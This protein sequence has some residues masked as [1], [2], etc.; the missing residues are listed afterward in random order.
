MKLKLKGA[1]LISL[2]FTFFNGQSQTIEITPSYGYQFGTKL[3]YGGSYIK[4]ESSDQYG[5]S[6]AVEMD[7]DLMVGVAYTRMSTELNIRDG[8]VND[9]I[10]ATL[11]DLN[12]DWIL[13]EGTRYFQTGKVR[14]FAGGGLGMVIV[15]PQNVDFDLRPNGLESQTRFAFSFKGGVNIMFSDR[16]GLNLQ[17]NLYVPVVWGGLYIGTGGSGVGAGSTTIMGGFSGGLVF[18][19]GD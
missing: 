12:F 17:G 3:D 7:D 10:E 14:P 19:L 9:G 11:S 16:V 13:L 4:A 18:L 1:L 6:M 5:I 8:R 2:L 15:S